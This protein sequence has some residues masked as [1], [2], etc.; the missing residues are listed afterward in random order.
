VAQSSLL[1]DVLELHRLRAELKS[2]NPK[3]AENRKL[4]D[5]ERSALATQHAQ[6]QAALSVI[7]QR[8]AAAGFGKRTRK[9]GDEEGFVTE[10][11]PVVARAVLDYFAS[12]PGQAVLDRLRGLGIAPR[13]GQTTAQTGKGQTLSGKTVVLTG[14]LGAMPRGKAA[15]EIRARGGNVTG[16]VTRKTDYLV[17]GESPG[18]KYDEA[19]ALGVAILDEAAF[20]ALLGG[21][22]EGEAGGNATEGAGREGGTLAPVQGDLL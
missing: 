8:L 5:Q 21:G 14:T 15:A 17:A 18:S 22:G 2:V 4:G 16:S 20:L 13:G 19:Q 10:L 9:N 12:A 1:E 6:T 7:E 11:G 3:A